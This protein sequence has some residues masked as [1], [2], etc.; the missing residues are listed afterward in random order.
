MRERGAELC[1][2]PEYGAKVGKVH[3][4]VFAV[5]VAH[6][7]ISY[8]AEGKVGVYYV[9]DCVVYRNS[10]LTRPLKDISALAFVLAEDVQGE[11]LFL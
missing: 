6:A 8:S 1:R 9:A 3:E 5:I 10:A 2:P 7:R 11:R 4:S